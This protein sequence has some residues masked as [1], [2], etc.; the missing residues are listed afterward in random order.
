MREAVALLNAVEG[1]LRRAH[2]SYAAP[3]KRILA[4]VKAV[5]DQSA[6]TIG[7]EQLA[8][9]AEVPN[10]LLLALSCRRTHEAQ[11]NELVKALRQ[12]DGASGK[13]VDE[14]FEDLSDEVT[15]WWELLRPGERAFF[16]SVQRRSPK[17]RRTIDLKVSLSASDDRSNPKLRDAVAV[18][19]QSQLHCLG[20]LCFWLALSTPT[21]GL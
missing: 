8:L 19:S 15:K 3:S 4:L 13:V 6:N 16:R 7:W 12:I 17:A 10:E 11:V 20:L 1:A 18:F 5:V 2:A 21:S 14:K 9:L